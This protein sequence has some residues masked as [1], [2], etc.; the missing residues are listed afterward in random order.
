[1]KALIGTLRKE[2][3]VGVTCWELRSHLF[4]AL[5][6][7]TFT[8]GPKIWGVGFKISHWKVSEKG[9]KMDMMPHI[10]VRSSTTYYLLL[11]GF[12]E[13]CIQ[14]YDLKLTM[15]FHQWLAHIPPFG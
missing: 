11:A 9:V 6:L 5:V 15:S 3:I 12:G 10:K 13:L 2:T 7:P 8:Y 4:K 1:M 14:L